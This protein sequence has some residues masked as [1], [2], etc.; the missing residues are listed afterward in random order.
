M[1][2]QTVNLALPYIL[3]AQAQKHVTHNEALQ[4]LDA[5]V[6]LV[7]KARQ[8]SPPA[9]PL[10]GECF[11][12]LAG[13]T[14]AWS[15]RAGRLAFRQ[16]GDWIFIA[17]GRGWCAFERGDGRLKIFDGADWV[18]V[19][20]P[21]TIR[22]SALGVGATPDA[23]NRVSVSAPST[24]LNHAGSDHRLTI[25]KA[26]SG[27]TASLLF[28][29]GWQGKAEMGLAGDDRFSIKVSPDGSTWTTALSITPQGVVQTGQRPLVRAARTAGSY[30]PA[31]GSTTGFDE[32]SLSSGGFAL[33]SALGSGVG[34]GLTVPMAGTYAVS[35][36]VEAQT[37]TGHTVTLR[38]NGSEEVLR[39]KGTAGTQSATVVAALAAGDVLSLLHGGIAVL[40]CGRARTELSAFLL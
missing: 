29:S 28:Q 31:D 2:E 10:E 7:I 6:Q 40:V 36:T 24:L 4:V 25:N 20:L 33:A 22:V 11:W 38:R 26:A 19:D 15:G 23:S 34:R 8:P 13:A 30:S 21:P 39:V 5:T 32:L 37:S 18:D 17:P 12:V 35:L 3:P 16:D 9:A 14:G 27:N 1:S